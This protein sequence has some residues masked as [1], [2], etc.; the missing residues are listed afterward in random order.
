MTSLLSTIESHLNSS[1]L[2]DNLTPLFCETLLWGRPQAMPFSR[3]VRL[4]Q[5]QEVDLTFIPTA[6]LSGLPV[7]RVDWPIDK[8][9][10]ITQRRAVHRAL[11]PTYLEHLLIYITADSQQVAFVWA[12]KRGSETGP[13][14]RVEMRTLPYNVGAPARITIEQLS[15]LAFFIEELGLFGEPPV[16]AVTDKLNAAFDIEAVTQG[17]FAAY[18]QVFETLRE[19]LNQAT[20]DL[21]WSHDHALQ[22][23]N[24]L[25]FLYFVQRKR[26]LGDDPA[27]MA[28]FWQTYKSDDCA[29]DTFFADWL[30]VLF[31]EAFNNRFQAGRPDYQAR[32]PE[33]IRQALAMAPYLNG[34]LFTRNDL[35]QQ[36]T[37]TIPD[38]FFALLFDRFDGHAP[39]FLERY[40]FT[41]TESTPFDIEVAVDP[42]MIGKVYESLVNVSE[43]ADE[44][45]EAGIFYTPRVEID[46]MCRLALVD[47]LTNHLGQ[48][49]KSALY[50]AIFAFEPDDKARADSL[51]AERNLWPQLNTLLR[52]VTVVDPACGSGSFLVG[53]LLVL[54]DLLTRADAQLGHQETPYERRKR[55]IGNSL[56]GVDVMQWAVHVAELRLWL[57]LV[58]ETDLAPAELKFRPLLPNL[59]FKVRP[60]DSL[61]QEV[62]GVNLA[63]RQGSGLI[64]PAL[65]GRITRLKGEKLKFYNNDSSCQY[66]TAEQLRQAESE[67][68][69][70]ILDARTQAIA[71]R[72]REIAEALRP[73]VNLFGEEQTTQFGFDRV[74]LEHEQERLETERE[75][76]AR[77]R[78]ALQNA[79]NVSPF[80]WDIAFVEVFEGDKGGFD[81]V[82]GNPPYVRQEA[83]H[84]PQTPSDQVTTAD[85]KAYKAKLAR[86]MYAAWPRTFGYDWA[87]D[88]SK[89]TLDAKSDL[90]IYF[91]LHGL[92][93]LNAQGAFCFITSN[94]WLDVGYGKDLQEFLLTRGQVKL[95]LDNQ[96]RRS[97]TNAEVNT[98]IALLGPPQDTKTAHPESLAYTTRFV[99]LTV[100]FE[101]ALTPV[102][103]EEVEETAARRTTPEYRLFPLKQAELLENGIDPEKKQF[104]GDKWGAKYLRAPDIYWFVLEKTRDRLTRLGEIVEVRRGFT[105]GANDFFYLDDQQIA[106]WGIEEEHVYWHL[107]TPRDSYR[108]TV[109]YSACTKLFL[110]NSPKSKLRGTGALEYIQWGESQG[111]HR[112]STCKARANW[113]ALGERPFPT[114]AWPRTFFERHICY[115]VPE[116]TFCSDRFYGLSGDMLSPTLLA[117][118]NS[119]YVSL[120]V[121]VNG[122]HVN[123]GGIDTSVWWLQTLP[124]LSGRYQDLEDVYSELRQRNIEL[125]RVELRLSDRR[126]LDEIIFDILRLPRSAVDDMYEVV[127]NMITGRILK[128]RRSPTKVNAL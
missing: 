10:T 44:Q 3:K 116:T 40:N 120:F 11:A 90:Y 67:L 4:D 111:H 125:A 5:E 58:I 1:R 46:L 52:E 96:V 32:F 107:A 77:A 41:I 81:I 24:R 91:Y 18:Q 65:K 113:Y 75:Q 22:V 7:F 87:K 37:V 78:Q 39:G 53:M 26:W 63:L 97:F 89:W 92:S 104:T 121:E 79:H 19:H 59:S 51:L 103:W 94:S 56:Y 85:K 36:Y 47:W 43:E 93:L 124:V 102:L 25:L 114:A 42:E 80:V 29:P 108:I 33:A 34:G 23:L 66:R 48:P 35:D 127:Q 62:G 13:A 15:A 115:E 49:H 128:A 60:G 86:A 100:P 14:A 76:V 73:Q 109:P 12:R 82:V 69:R 106:Q 27:F 61:V 20:Q 50:E 64:P 45:G 72:R 9:P 126:T 88:K 6:Q 123:H 68:F 84:D 101:E 38:T 8:P 122:Y 99:M 55:I 31:F 118:L 83:I 98:I 110:C 21:R 105:T 17:F 119:T 95:V 71:A 117:C 112:K 30:C 16:T 54:D 70:D 2:R 57:Q 28:H 74:A